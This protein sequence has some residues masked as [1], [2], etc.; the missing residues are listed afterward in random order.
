MNW[1]KILF[2]LGIRKRDGK[3]FSVEFTSWFDHEAVVFQWG[4]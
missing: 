4:R 3:E 2:R 1:N